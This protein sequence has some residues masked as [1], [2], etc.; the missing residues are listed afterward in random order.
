MV[1]P[2]YGKVWFFDGAAA[3]PGSIVAS[4]EEVSQLED[5]AVPFRSFAE[6]RDIAAQRIRLQ[7]QA[8]T[9]YAQAV[10]PPQ[11]I[12]LQDQADTVYAQAVQPPSFKVPTLAV[13]RVNSDG[14][15]GRIVAASGIGGLSTA[16]PD[17]S[18][19]TLLAQPTP[20]PRPQWVTVSIPQGR[21]ALSATKTLSSRRAFCH[22]EPDTS[23]AGALA[24]VRHSGKATNSTVQLRLIKKTPPK[25][26]LTPQIVVLKQKER[27]ELLRNIAQ[28]EGYCGSQVL[29]RLPDGVDLGSGS[30]DIIQQQ[31]DILPVQTP[32]NGNCL[33][34]AL[35]QALAN[36]DL[37][38]RD[39]ILL[40]ATSSLK[41]GIKYTRQMH[42]MDQFSHQARVTT[43]VNVARGWM[44]MPRSGAT[45]QFKW[46]LE[47]YASSLTNPTTM[48]HVGLLKRESKL[49]SPFKSVLRKRAVKGDRSSPP[50]L[51]LKYEDGH[52]S[53]F[54]HRLP[55]SDKATRDER[56][57]DRSVSCGEDMSDIV[58]DSDEKMKEAAELIEATDQFDDLERNG[59]VQAA[60]FAP[61][62]PLQQSHVP[63][64][65]TSADPATG[66]GVIGNSTALA[67]RV[68][69]RASQSSAP[70][71]RNHVLAPDEREKKAVIVRNQP[72]ALVIKNGS[73]NND[74][75]LLEAGPAKVLQLESSKT[76]QEIGLDLAKV[77]FH[78][79][80][81]ACAV[82]SSG[83]SGIETPSPDDSTISA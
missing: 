81:F 42:M 25:L 47:E 15:D 64:T 24:A 43:L 3:W 49:L 10:Q 77:V 26:P 17:Q 57:V 68:S 60:I 20:K 29:P 30:Y 18:G 23:G 58:S 73:S 82:G 5:L 67:L 76:W 78:S 14:R 65:S 2:Y 69:P 39:K 6:M 21:K 4:E 70:T 74:R 37:R 33:A 50:P 63:R 8:D 46:Y 22:R 62:S 48:L 71:T 53:A 32:A 34:M 40:S 83:E 19:Q 1:W 51:I 12:R 55:N 41:R 27:T 80:Q 61:P 72:T 31:L 52:Y 79:L 28:L 44:G 7:D 38:H 75:L 66:R 13:D 35:V 59:A 36:N 56:N 16:Q 9:V 54:V 11:R 45:K